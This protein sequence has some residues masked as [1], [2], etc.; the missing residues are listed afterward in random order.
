MIAQLEEENLE[1]LREMA[2]LEQ[3]QV[4]ADSSG[5]LLG[6][7]DKTVEL[8]AKMHE[9]QQLRRQ[10]IQ[11]L[12]Q[13]MAKLNVSG[14]TLVFEL[15]ALTRLSLLFPGPGSSPKQGWITATQSRNATKSIGRRWKLN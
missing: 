8:E 10:L 5:H 11:Q 2:A 1:M 6:L 4:L 14:I 7:R 13:L 12:E 9:K 3:Q 15:N